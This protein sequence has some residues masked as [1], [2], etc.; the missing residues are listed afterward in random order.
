MQVA[1]NNIKPLDE[2]LDPIK[3]MAE[4]RNT[5]RWSDNAISLLP[6]SLQT[7]ES[8]WNIKALVP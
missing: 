8:S 7:H 3:N 5:I 1:S 4:S 2:G 6:E